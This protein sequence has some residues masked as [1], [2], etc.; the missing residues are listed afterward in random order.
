MK[1]GGPWIK[2]F[3][4]RDPDGCAGSDCLLNV[5]MLSL[6][7]GLSFFDRPRS[8]FRVVQS[9]HW[10][11]QAGMNKENPAMEG[12]KEQAEDNLRLPRFVRAEVR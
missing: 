9:R 7:E 12:D 1:R 10:A 5:T 8:T 4:F 11:L 3:R 2:D 6:F